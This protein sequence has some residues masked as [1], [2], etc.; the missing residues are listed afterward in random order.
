MYKEH[1]DF[2]NPRN[3]ATKVWRFV[4]FTKF[5][6]MLEN[7]SLYFA[8]S[9]KLDDPF[10]GAFTKFDLVQLQSDETIE[11][12]VKKAQIQNATDIQ[13]YY[14]KTRFLNCWSMNEYESAALWKI[15]TNNNQGVAIQSTFQKFTE[16]FSKS[17]QTIHVGQI[18]YL[19]Y[20]NDSFGTNN[21]YLPFL[22]KRKSFE[23]E[24]EIRAIIED[25][26]PELT[27]SE[28]EKIDKIGIDV[29]VDLD[30]LIEN[31]FVAPS[32]HVWF[33]DL[34]KSIGKRYGL[35]KPIIDSKLNDR[36]HLA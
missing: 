8:R 16:C 3:L 11:D 30:V 26:P 35:E 12:G 20:D 19:D 25:Y 4:D 32:A 1:I 21:V 34:I 36:P 18:D 5:V 10:E 28:F 2:K 7:Q 22:H 24:H 23:Y 13:K 6:S 33:R 9:D 31:I 15:F 29:S 27:S 14:P 17:D